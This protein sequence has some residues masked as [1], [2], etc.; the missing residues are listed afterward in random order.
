M[1]LKQIKLNYDLSVFLNA[2]YSV[3]KG[4]CISYQRREQTDIHDGL[5]NGF[6]DSYH[7]DNT[8]I[9]QIWFT[10]EQVNNKEL[11]NQLGIWKL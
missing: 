7:E 10:E 11:G 5:G 1:I 2:D 6:P 3:H 9:Q 8:R 4:S